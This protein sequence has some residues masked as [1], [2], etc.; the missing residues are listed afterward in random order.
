MSALLE[1]VVNGDGDFQVAATGLLRNRGEGLGGGHQGQGAF[2]QDG[3]AAGADHLGAHQLALAGDDQL[4]H[5]V[6]LPAAGGGIS[7]A[8]GA[9]RGAGSEATAGGVTRVGLGAS[10]WRAT[11]T[12]RGAT[13]LGVGVAWGGAAGAGGGGAAAATGAGAGAGWGGGR[14]VTRIGGGG[15]GV[16]RRQSG[17]RPRAARCTARERPRAAPARRC[18]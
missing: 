17:R 9:G 1:L 15:G 8:T 14:R 11:R 13:G 4:Q 16:L 7:L 3:V 12:G 18:G 2:V 6:A 10:A 5:H